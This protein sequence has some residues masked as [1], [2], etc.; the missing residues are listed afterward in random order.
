MTFSK[1]EGAWE[2]FHNVNV[3]ELEALIFYFPWF[4]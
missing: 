3:V 1:K 2:H 4:H